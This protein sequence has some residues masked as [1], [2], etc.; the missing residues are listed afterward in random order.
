MQFERYNIDWGGGGVKHQAKV[1]GPLECV[2]DTTE[3]L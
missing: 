2:V 1:F 3:L